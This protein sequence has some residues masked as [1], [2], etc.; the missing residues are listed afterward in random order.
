MRDR[1]RRISAFLSIRSWPRLGV[2]VLAVGGMYCALSLSSDRSLFP[3]PM[4]QAEGEGEERVIRRGRKRRVVVLGSGWGAVSFLREVKAA[5]DVE[6]VCVSP[7]NYFLMTPLLP[8][9]TVGTSLPLSL[10]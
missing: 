4:A 10:S 3:L 1:T 2:A 7:T 8:S 9:A 5:G 6:I